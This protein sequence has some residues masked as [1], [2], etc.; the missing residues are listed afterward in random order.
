M[1]DSD[2]V[3]LPELVGVIMIILRNLFVGHDDARPHV[4]HKERVHNQLLPHPRLKLFEGQV[5]LLEGLG[6][7][8]IAYDA[9]LL[10]DLFDGCRHL[11]L[12]HDDVFLRCLLQLQLAKDQGIKNLSLGNLQLPR[13]VLFPQLVPHALD[14]RLSLLL[15]LAEG[16][17][18]VVDYG[19]HLIDEDTLSGD[20]RRSP[21]QQRKAQDQ[22]VLVHHDPPEPPSG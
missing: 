21:D 17:Y 9:V 11:F 15:E 12:I 7:L 18:L 8:G 5:L 1:P 3:R 13:G 20:H 2:G 14:K 16:N 6:E 19:N 4:A 10:F 22:S